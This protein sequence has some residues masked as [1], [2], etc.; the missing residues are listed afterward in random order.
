MEEGTNE[1]TKFH[2]LKLLSRSVLYSKI[3]KVRHHFPLP[4][5][6]KMIAKDDENWTNVAQKRDGV[7]GLFE[8]GNQ[9]SHSKP[10]ITSSG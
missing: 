2:I 1:C 3:V 5:A 7:V 4:D 9:L 10:R 8:N 6:I